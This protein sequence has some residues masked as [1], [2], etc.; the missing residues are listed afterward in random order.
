MERTPQFECLVDRVNFGTVRRHL[1]TAKS[2]LTTVLFVTS[3]DLLND[4]AR[5]LDASEERSPLSRQHHLTWLLETGRIVVGADKQAEQDGIGLDMET[6]P[7][8]THCH[9]VFL[10]PAFL[11]HVPGLELSRCR[12]RRNPCPCP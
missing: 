9:A 10:H 5:L 11:V 2:P 3:R 7:D 6:I 1:A 4:V 8:A 12:Q